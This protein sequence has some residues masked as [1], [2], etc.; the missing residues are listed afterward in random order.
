[1]TWQINQ[2]VA[3]RDYFK[4]LPSHIKEGAFPIIESLSED[5]WQDFL[6]THPLRHPLSGYYACSVDS[7]YRILMRI[8]EQDIEITFWAIGK[9]RIYDDFVSL[10][11]LKKRIKESADSG[12]SDFII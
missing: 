6:R 10:L 9:H 12:L 4:R 7:D 11:N 8:K 1:M 2:T 5:P 3:F